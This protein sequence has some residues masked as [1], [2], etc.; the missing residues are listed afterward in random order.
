MLASKLEI[1]LLTYNRE[2]YLKKTL[3]QVFSTHSP[4]K[5]LKFTILN[6]CSTDGTDNLIS[7]YK[8][9]FP[10]LHHIRH[11]RNIGGNANICRAFE[12]A[13]HPYVWVLCDDDEYDWTHWDE[14]EKAI[15]ENKDLIVVANY[16]APEESAVNLIKQLTF[17]PAGIY[18]TEHFSAGMMINAYY[19]ISTMFPQIG[20][21]SYYIN[22]KLDIYIC[23]NWAVRMCVNEEDASYTR[24][25]EK[26]KPHP[27][28]KNNY[29]QFGFA[30]AMQLF[31]DPDLRERL[32]EN[33]N[34]EPVRGIEGYLHMLG[35]TKNLC[36]NNYR[37]L[38]EL[39]CALNDRQR[40]EFIESVI[41]FYSPEVVAQ[42]LAVY[43]KGNSSIK[44]TVMQSVYISE[45]KKYSA[46]FD[47]RKNKIFW[48]IS[49]LKILTLRIWDRAWV[50]LRRNAKGIDIVLGNRAKLRIWSPKW[51][52]LRKTHKGTDIIIFEKF[53]T[54]I[55]PGKK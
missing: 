10:S 13:T 14:V 38:T 23:K 1:F 55:W 28:M 6:N 37:N 29:W 40:R 26:T 16:L 45:E 17:V 7:Q 39:F 54:R 5:N 4:I 11:A 41:H 8:E 18:K 19:N 12:L 35:I 36:N 44:N 30:T 31:E 20:I 27:Y 52:R 51:F 15:A 42:K 22:S 3:E 24:G 46:W 53:K 21:V 9:K 49:L 47:F 33:I 34:I 25:V 2:K 43:I 50:H 32:A 48:E